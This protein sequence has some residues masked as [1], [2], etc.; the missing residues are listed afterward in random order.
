M[1][2]GM[3]KAA[4]FIMAFMILETNLLTAWAGYWQEGEAQTW[5]H[6]EGG[7]CMKG[8]TVIDGE[9]YFFNQEGSMEKGWVRPDG[10]GQW[11]YLNEDT[12]I[13][14]DTPPMSQETVCHLLENCMVIMNLYQNEESEVIYRVEYETKDIY[15][16][17]IGIEDGPDR[18]I[19]INIYEVDKKSGVA[20]SSIR[21]H[22]FILA[23]Q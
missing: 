19:P 12:G 10:E 20:K 16:I 11:Y 17:W 13:W 9:W 22:T 14:E 4:L 6:I 1:R 18:E 15:R 23:Y 2:K 21:D 5:S 7:V 3:K 8:W